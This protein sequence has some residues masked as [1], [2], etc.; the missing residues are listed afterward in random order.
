M[1]LQDEKMYNLGVC[2]GFVACLIATGLVY[3]MFF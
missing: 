2:V 3:L 1:N